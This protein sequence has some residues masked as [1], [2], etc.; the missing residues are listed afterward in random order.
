MLNNNKLNIKDITFVDGTV[1]R[2]NTLDSVYDA[3][4]LPTFPEIKLLI[5][6]NLIFSPYNCVFYIIQVLI[7]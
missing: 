3:L 1:Y 4:Q 7:Y 6:S 5:Y 2:T